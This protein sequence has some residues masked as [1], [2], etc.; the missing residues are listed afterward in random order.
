MKVKVNT[1]AMG[2]CHWPLSLL[3]YCDRSAPVFVIHRK[4][5]R[6]WALY[7][8]SPFRE[9]FQFGQ[10]LVCCSSDGAPVS[11]MESAPL[12]A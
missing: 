10:F 4:L 12:H 3:A 9:R 8:L 7:V 5:L 1:L 2:F 11:Y 6:F